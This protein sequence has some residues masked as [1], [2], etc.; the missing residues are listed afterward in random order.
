MSM[1]VPSF[2]LWYCTGEERRQVVRSC[3]RDPAWSVLVP[4]PPEDQP[5]KNG[6]FVTLTRLI[7]DTMKEGHRVYLVSKKLSDTGGV[8]QEVEKLLDGEWESRRDLLI[9]QYSTSRPH[10]KRPGGHALFIGYYIDAG[11]V[12]AFA[13]GAFPSDRINARVIIV[14]LQGNPRVVGLT[15]KANTKVRRFPAY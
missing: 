15:P 3:D 7:A 8:S 6:I 2:E 13:H 1:S 12:V 4:D 10:D 11:F 5:L 14:S 9:T